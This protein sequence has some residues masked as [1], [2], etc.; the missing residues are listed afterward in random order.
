MT[1]NAS[2]TYPTFFYSVKCDRRNSGFPEASCY[3]LDWRPADVH[4]GARGAS[5]R[6]LLTLHPE[7]VGFET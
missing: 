3:E 4:T 7:L 2:S 6:W 1:R 5:G